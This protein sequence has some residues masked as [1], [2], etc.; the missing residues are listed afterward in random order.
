M[1]ISIFLKLYAIALP[2]FLVIDLVWLGLVARN[3]YQDKLGHLLR[4]EVNWY[5]AVVFY[6][7]FVLGMVILV[8]WP[9]VERQSVTR[10]LLLGALLGAIAYSAYDLT[11]LATMEGFPT[12]VAVVDIIWGAVLCSSVCAITAAVWL[13]GK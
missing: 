4:P 13:W 7:L 6:L 5:A 10:A 12:L 1:P 3:F 11:N 8:V 9:A 2:T